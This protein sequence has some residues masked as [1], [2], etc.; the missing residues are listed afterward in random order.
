MHWLRN[1]AANNPIHFTKC[2]KQ[3]RMP[4]KRIVM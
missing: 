4:L 2:K 1:R 3:K